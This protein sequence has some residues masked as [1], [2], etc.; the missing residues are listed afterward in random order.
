MD[1]HDMTIDD[2]VDFLEKLAKEGQ[3]TRA[4]KTRLH[5]S[6]PPCYSFVAAIDINKTALMYAYVL[7]LKNDIECTEAE[8]AREAVE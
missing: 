8:Q 5:P 7:R 1:M 6:D 4:R 2:V 3:E